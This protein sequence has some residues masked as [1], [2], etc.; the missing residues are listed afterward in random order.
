MLN[1]PEYTNEF[2]AAEIQQHKVMGILGFIPP[3]FFLPLVATSGSRVGRFW[4]NQG[5]LVLIAYG[6]IGA[7]HGTLSAI[8]SAIGVSWLGGLLSPVYAIPVLLSVFGIVNTS[9]GRVRDIPVI[10]HFRIFK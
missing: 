2:D 4:A 10:G 8:F 9:K 6:A 7:A 1:T 3:L 5:L